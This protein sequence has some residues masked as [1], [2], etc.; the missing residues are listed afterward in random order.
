[1]KKLI[2]VLFLAVIPFLIISAF[3]N[4]LYDDYSYSNG[5]LNSG[6][7][8]SQINLYHAWA[9][10]YFSNILLSLNPIIWGNFIA[11]KII[12]IIIIL[13]TFVSLYSFIDVLLRQSLDLPAKLFGASLITVL[14][15]TRCP[16]LWTEFIGFPALYPINLLIF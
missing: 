13:L 6:F 10:R 5:V 1:M 9:G 16:T 11:Y 14:F 15:L 7:L 3:V 4:P 2:F 12:P 8:N